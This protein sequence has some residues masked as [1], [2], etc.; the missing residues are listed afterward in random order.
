MGLILVVGD[1]NPMVDT[2][3]DVVHCNL[4][5]EIFYSMFVEPLPI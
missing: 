2:T 1:Q 3:I 4:Y 5:G